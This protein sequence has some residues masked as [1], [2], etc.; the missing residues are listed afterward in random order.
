MMLKADAAA[1]K[2]LGAAL[3]KSQPALYRESQKS[4]RVEGQKI[5]ER[6]KS[7]ASWSTRIPQT[8][9]V[10]AAGVNAVI[11]SAGGQDAPHAKPIEHAGAEGTF[12]HPVGGN[13]D[14]WVDQPARPFLHPAALERLQES[15][16]AV[17]AA[18]TVQVEKTLHGVDRFV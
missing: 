6:A 9:R 17:A 18:L 10:R 1:L 5:A 3:R 12:R 14:V 16:E 8:V 2:N 13:R 4:L 7:N 11:V 15:A